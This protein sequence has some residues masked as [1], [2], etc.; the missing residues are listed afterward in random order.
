MDNMADQAQLLRQTRLAL[1]ENN[2]KEAIRCLKQAAQLARDAGDASSEGRHLGNL[3]LIYYRTQQPEKALGAFQKALASA[4]TD[5]DRLTEDGIL[6]NMGNILRE[7]GR[8]DDAIAHLNQA[9]LIAQ[10]IGDVRGRGI[11]LSNLGLVYDDLQQPGKAVDFHR[12][13][14]NVARLIHD[15]RGLASR[16]ANLGN[17]YIVMANTTE[18]LKCYHETVA[19]YKTLGDLAEAALRQGIIGNI[20]SDLGRNSPSNEEATICYGLAADAYRETLT[21]AQELNDYAAQA[22]LLSS[23]GNVFGN[24]GNYEQALVNFRDAHRLF[25][26]LGL[27]DRLPHLE[28]NINLAEDLRLQQQS[29][30]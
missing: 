20:Y 6:G 4:R 16:L 1:Q 3:A 28:H 24:M 7:I 26:R 9:L 12:E 23:L 2:F 15:Q 13:A 17:S 18:A 25:T 19:V 10:E 22:E 29:G 27:R 5:S 14:V 21:L 8:Y 11:W 30:Q